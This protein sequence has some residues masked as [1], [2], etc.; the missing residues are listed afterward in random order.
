MNS[1]RSRR[2][3]GDKR[4]ETSNNK[5]R[6]RIDSS[7]SEFVDGVIIERFYIFKELLNASVF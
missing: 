6:I 3:R 4:D 5:Y 7:N 2:T 1:H